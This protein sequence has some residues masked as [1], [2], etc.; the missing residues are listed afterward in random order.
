MLP[1]LAILSFLFSVLALPTFDD[2][3]HHKSLSAN[4]LVPQTSNIVVLARQR[5]SNNNNNNNNEFTY[6]LVLHDPDFPGNLTALPNVFNS[7]SFHIYKNR[8]WVYKNDS[9]IWPVNF[10]NDTQMRGHPLQMVVGAKEFGVKQGIWSW[11]DTRLHYDHGV[12]KHHFY[13]CPTPNGHVGVF[14]YTARRGALFPMP[15]KVNS[16]TH[17]NRFVPADCDAITFSQRSP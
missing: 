11:R 15:A 7:P 9:A 5:N 12:G 1:I 16:H 4:P 3:G 6:D 8:L 13:L 14:M 17:Y 10:I 2:F